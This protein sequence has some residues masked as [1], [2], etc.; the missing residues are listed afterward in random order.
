MLV[1]MLLCSIFDYIAF[2]SAIRQL[3]SWRAPNLRGLT[4][5]SSEKML[6]S[7]FKRYMNVRWLLNA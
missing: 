1:L 5:L 7:L 4:L 6:A 2:N 3:K